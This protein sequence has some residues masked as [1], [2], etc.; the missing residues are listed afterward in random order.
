MQHQH[1]FSA[2]M[3]AKSLQLCLTLCDPV[4]CNPP[5]SSVHAISQARLLEW[6]AMPSSRHEFYINIQ[7]KNTSYLH[8]DHPLSTSVPLCLSIRTQFLLVSV[9]WKVRNERRRD[10]VD[11]LNTRHQILK[12]L[13]QKS[14]TS[15]CD[16]ISLYKIIAYGINVFIMADF[17]SGWVL[18]PRRTGG[19]R[20]RK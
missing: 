1:E 15:K 6:L 20:R 7:I 12:C 17:V 14:L 11:T 9:F 4:D 19:E 18:Q 5:G 2:C 13:K 3:H 16:K 8:T 10:Q